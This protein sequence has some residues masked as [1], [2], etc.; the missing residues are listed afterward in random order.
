MKSSD[1]RKKFTEYFKKKGHKQLPSASL[2][3]EQDLSLLFVNAG[4]NQ[5]KSVFLGLKQPPAKN[6]VTIQKCMRAGGKHNDLENVGHTPR[7]H[8]FFEMMG[9]FSFGGYFKKEALELS[10]EFLTKGLGLSEKRLWVS[11]FKDDRETERL[12]KKHIGLPESRIF[13]CG[14][15]ENFWRMGDSGPC[16]PCSEIHY[17]NGSKQKP[18]PE[19]L[20]EIWNLVFMEFNEDKESGR[21]PLPVPCVD[22][23]MGLERLTAVLQ[24]RESN[25]HTDLFQGII[26]SLEKESGKSYDWTET[27]QNEEQTAFR[28][29][30]DHSRAITFL[31]SEGV[32]PGSEGADYVL[33]RILRRALF[34]SRKLHPQKNLLIDGSQVTAE[35]MGDIYPKLKESANKRE[36]KL[37]IEEEAEMFDQKLSE[38]KK[39]LLE[40]MR[41][42]EGNFID[43][44]TADMLYGTYGFPVDLTRLIAGEKGWGMAKDSEIEQQKQRSANLFK[45]TAMTESRIQC[46]KSN[47]PKNIPQTHFTGDTTDGEEGRVMCILKFRQERELENRDND[48]G[49]LSTTVSA[50]LSYDLPDQ[51]RAGEK[52]WVIFNKTCFYPED[53]GELKTE[54]GTAQILGCQK[55]HNFIV[56]E[57]TALKGELKKDQLCKLRVDKK[58]R[59]LLKESAVKS[60]LHK[61]LNI[62]LKTQFTGYKKN[63]EEGQILR[64]FSTGSPSQELS[65]F[66]ALSTEPLKE[67]QTGYVVLD[68]TCLYP[69]GGGPVGD[70]GVL[71]TATGQ[72]DVLDCKKFGSFIFHEVRVT[73]GQLKAK[74]S[75]PAG[76]NEGS[77]AERD[78]ISV[79]GRNEV[80]AAERDEI[81]V[82]ER[83]KISVEETKCKMKVDTDHRKGISS[84]HSATHLLHSALRQILGPSTRQ[85]GSLVEPYRLRFD[86]SCSRPLTLKQQAQIE[87]EVVSNIEKGEKVSAKTLP[88]KQA[89]REGAL[90]LPGENYGDRVRII[91]MGDHTSKEFCGGIHVKNTADIGSFRIISESGV[92]SGVRRITALTGPLAEKWG[93]L[94]EREN[95][96]LR[97]QL[98]LPDFF[99]GEKENPFIEWAEKI[100]REIKNLKKQTLSP[101]SKK[102]LVTK[103]AY[104][105]FNDF[106]RRSLLSRQ[107]LELRVYLNLSAPKD[108]EEKNPFRDFVKKKEEELKKVKAQSKKLKA[109]SFKP[110][111]L[112]KQAKNF[113]GKTREGL[114]LA[115]SLPLQDRKLLADLADNLKSRMPTGIVILVGEGEGRHPVVVTLTKDLQQTLSAGDILKKIISPLLKG[116]GGGQARFAQGAV[117]DKSRFSE[118]EGALLELLKQT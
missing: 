30:A 28:V 40:T 65:G 64:T 6:V 71:K 108:T 93:F 98:G 70:K 75:L 41:R 36:T 101:G 29:L 52:A 21:T 15:T 13:K 35:I 34:Y 20:L 116:K 51:L 56:H 59:R 49:D 103:T 12:W 44:E 39:R 8:T 17:Y 37:L 60:Q 46:I 33:R 48:G 76:R 87:E 104:V 66:V 112:L 88:R 47:P 114:L 105:S 10:W 7:H 68:R 102:E 53:K 86:F 26:Q 95:R 42:R 94:L 11:V 73:K 113:Q 31:I 85:A 32:F 81:S 38:G 92:Q 2:I 82:E 14:E 89:V 107:N 1:I 25:Y 58:H 24:N 50:K 100:D 4:M 79:E 74:S 106:T 62:N 63:E 91:T 110:E 27:E 18:S 117:T 72:A 45:K 118:L 111:E 23:G 54:T 5:F 55:I 78:E 80:S 99:P 3:P 61:Y 115:V 90:F 83:D 97:K 109:P 67:G 57:V 22:T 19:D 69:E 77:T 9:N 43:A 16:G 84:A 96:E